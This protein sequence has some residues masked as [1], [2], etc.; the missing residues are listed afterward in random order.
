MSGT[1]VAGARA[2]IINFIKINQ[3]ILNVLTR[4]PMRNCFECLISNGNEH[5]TMILPVIKTVCQVTVTT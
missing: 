3:P 1:L 4:Q 5:I 2:N